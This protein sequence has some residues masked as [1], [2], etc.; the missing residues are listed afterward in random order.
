MQKAIALEAIRG[1]AAIF[2]V[3]CH[4]T[5]SFLTKLGEIY[6]VGW[7]PTWE[8]SV[9]FILVNGPG[10]VVLFFVLSGYVLTRR[11]F[12]DGQSM[13]LLRGAVKRWPRLLGPVLIS[14]LLS[15]A[16]FKSG[17]YR[18]EDAGKLSGSPWLANFAVVPGTLLVP[19]WEAAFA[20]GMFFTFFRGDNWFDTSLWTMRPELLGSFIA[21]GGAAVLFEARKVSRLVVVLLTGLMVLFAHFSQPVLA[22]FPVGVAMAALLGRGKLRPWWGLWIIGITGLYFLGY[23]GSPVGA[24]SL[25]SV[26]PWL[27]ARPVYFQ[28]IGAACIISIVEVYQPLERMLSNRFFAFLGALSFPIYLLH[29][30]V[31]CSIGSE[32]YIEAGPVA[33][34]IAVFIVSI[35]AS[36]PLIA[37]NTWWVGSL[38]GITARLVISSASSS[39]ASRDSSAPD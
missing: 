20:Q 1:I 9:L 4:S 2:V 11:F 33:A 25:L 38:N 21:F 23:A 34:I 37:F 7:N 30:L 19:T 15:C 6:P 26:I 18:F 14:T 31:I 5:I 29:F 22:A 12:E 24:Y 39:S 35:A 28:I 16:L 32:I 3:L 17:L 10:A 27:A 8:G 13:I 36:L